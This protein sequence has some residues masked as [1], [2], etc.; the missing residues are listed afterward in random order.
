MVIKIS[1]IGPD[2]KLMEI[3]IATNKAGHSILSDS[4]AIQDDIVEAVQTVLTKHLRRLNDA[5]ITNPNN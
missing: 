2:D 5:K 3:T 4:P 1:R